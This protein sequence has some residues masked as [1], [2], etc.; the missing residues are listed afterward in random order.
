MKMKKYPLN[1]V[2]YYSTFREM[3]EALPKGREDKPGIS[4]FT[5]KGEEQGVTIGKLRDDVRGLAAYFVKT[6]LAGKHIGI[7][8]ENSYEWILVYFAAT[9]CGSVAVCVDIEQP[10]DTIAQMLEMADVSAIFCIDS[11][12]DICANFAGDKIRLTALTRDS[13]DALIKE[14]A[15]F[16]EFPEVNG[17]MTA[18]IVFT[19]GTM[20]YSKPVMLA[21]SAILTNASDALANV[22]IGERAFTSLPF[23]HTYGLTCSVLSMLIGKAHL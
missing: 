23:Y 13:L 21:Q 16:D 6:G 19:S 8:G 12:R 7:L 9:Y 22:A 1:K 10:D 17:D 4:W 15:G 11:V 3:I 14:G 20:N 5:R 2:E 18:A